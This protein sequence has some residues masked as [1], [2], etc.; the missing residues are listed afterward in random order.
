[1]NK[2]IIKEFSNSIKPNGNNCN[3][4]RYMGFDTFEQ[5][6]SFLKEKTNQW[7]TEYGKFAR[8]S[9]NEYDML[10]SNAANDDYVHYTIER[11]IKNDDAR[12]VADHKL[13][14]W[15]C[16][17]KWMYD[18]DCDPTDYVKDVVAAGITS[19][20]MSLYSM[21]HDL[22]AKKG[23][24][25]KTDQNVWELTIYGIYYVE[26]NIYG[27]RECSSND[28]L[29][30]NSE[31]QSSNSSPKLD[32]AIADNAKLAFQ[33]AAEAINI[34]MDVLKNSGWL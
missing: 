22:E 25:E 8:V 29:D 18:T 1:M 28:K 4:E 7:K 11:I 16:L 24:I 6:S 27:N 15:E 31:Q 34:A 10:F 14:K 13:K 2:Y 23:L 20:K 32:S 9:G 21:L 12:V 17:L 3:S 5:L 26:T 19:N 30:E 33:K